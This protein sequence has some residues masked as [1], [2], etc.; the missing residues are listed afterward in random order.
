MEFQTYNPTTG[1]AL[2]RREHWPFEKAEKQLNESWKDFLVWR[3]RSP[4]DRA[5]AV[6]LWARSLKNQRDRL[7]RMMTEE[8]GKPIRQAKAEIDKCIFTCEYLAAEGPKFLE[9]QRHESPYHESWVTYEPLGPILAIMPW[10][11]PLWQVVRFAAPALIAGNTVLLKHADLTAGCAEIIG[12]SARDLVDGLRLIRNLPIDHEVA[13]DLMRH[14]KIRGVTFTGSTRGGREVAR[15]AGEAL[16][17]TVLELGGSDAYIVLSDADV[18][19]AA[20]TCAAARLVNG[21]QSCVAAK[22]FIV[23]RPAA[24]AFVSALVNEMKA[25]QPGDPFD[26]D[27]RLGP[28]AA[29]KFQAQLAEQVEDLQKLGGRVVLGGT[30]PEGPAAYYPP[31]VIVFERPTPGVGDIETFGPVAVV[32]VAADA[33]EAMRAANDSPYGLGGALFT[34]D[35]TKGLDLLRDFEAGFVVL[36]GS[37]QSDVRLPF[38]GVKD[39]GHGRELSVHGLHEFCN[40]KTVAQGAR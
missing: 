33:V 8:M 31:T 3:R 36:N 1:D 25:V 22:R 19:A 21:G 14:P 20:K 11:F 4:K 16:K 15:T 38:G 26:E 34:A 12:E 39:S 40:I 30:V 9:P 2:Q 28:L 5:Q 29:K 23:E 35:T 7:A 32:I 18:I 10:N 37:V 17:K 13:A 6:A 24:G 27:C